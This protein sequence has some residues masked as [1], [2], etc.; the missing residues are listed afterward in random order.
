MTVRFRNGNKLIAEFSG[1]VAEEVAYKIVSGSIVTHEV[2]A[3]KKNTK[4]YVV[5]GDY[6]YSMKKKSWFGFDDSIEVF[7]WTGYCII[8]QK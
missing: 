4:A 3:I 1:K 2:Q 5:D 6:S 7:F 8:V